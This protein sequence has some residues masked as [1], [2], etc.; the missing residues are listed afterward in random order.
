MP[1]T[2]VSALDR[3]REFIWLALAEGA[4]RRELCRRFGVSPTL[5]YRLLARHQ[6]EGD[7]GLVERSRRPG[8]SPAMTTP[9]VEAQVLALRAEH[10]AWGR[11]K[12]AAVLRR[13]GLAGPA[14]STVTGI[15]RGNGV[16]LGR[17][18]EAEKARGRFE[19]P[20]PN[21]LWQMDFKGHVAMR[22][23]R[24]HPL[25]VLDDHSRFAVVLAAC[26][27]ERTK[28]VKACLIEAFRR[29]GLP[30][31][32]TCDNSAPWGGGASDRF[33]P[34]AVWLIE[35]DIRVSHSRPFHPQTQGKDERFHRSLKAE[36]MSG[37]PFIGQNDAAR[38]FERWRT[39]YNTERPHEGI[40]LMVPIERYRQSPRSYL[41]IIEPFVYGP[42]DQ[43]RT[44]TS[45]G[46]FNFRSRAW[47]AP[48]AFRG[49]RLAV[50][51]T[52]TDGVYDVI[53]RTTHVTSI[54]LRR[55]MD[56]SQPVTDVSVHLSRMSPV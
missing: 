19:H 56:H 55:P 4:N 35:Q 14:P 51:P 44:V 37:P 41:E 5:A 48:K 49:K 25:T 8:S 27:N 36:A 11:R 45:S 32:F 42:D 2:G 34:L 30:W 54:D 15:L 21:D 3:K 53:F 39:I 26:D 7:S 28:T 33:T 1:F 17:L 22:S 47:R 12:I 6:A 18:S 29:Y 20:E 10:P 13:R 43:L 23:G 52:Q 24:L 31:R 16:E 9:E 46:R 40:G 38:A 50:R